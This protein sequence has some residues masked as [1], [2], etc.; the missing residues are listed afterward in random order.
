M[1]TPLERLQDWVRAY[2]NEAGSNERIHAEFTRRTDAVAWLKA[3]RDTIEARKWGHGDRAFHHLWFL[4]LQDLATRG[5]PL[6]LLEIGVF[7]GQVVSLWGVLA[8]KLGVEARITGVSP[9]EGNDPRGLLPL[10][11]HAMK[12][13]LVPSYRRRWR[14]LSAV[15]S[16]YPKDDYYAVVE[17]VLEHFGVPRDRVE[18]IRGS[19]HDATVKAK[20]GQGPFD[21][22]YIDGDHSFEGA[23][24]DVR[25]YSGLVAPDGYLVMDDAAWFLPGSTFFKGYESVSRAAEELPSLGF[26]NVLNVGHN[27]VYRR[28]RG[29]SAPARL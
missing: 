17:G 9:F 10:V 13:R 20:V 26:E 14:S 2:R 3:H 5:R 7:K 25:E 22:V 28:A 21:I 18:L 12:L 29:G 15:G 19:S 16:V 6:R 1:G 11:W 24:M 23:R 27:R 4:L 8:N